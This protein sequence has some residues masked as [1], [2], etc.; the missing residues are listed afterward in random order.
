MTLYIGIAARL[1]HRGALLSRAAQF[2]RWAEIGLFQQNRPIPDP[3]TTRNWRHCRVARRLGPM[4]SAVRR[5][6]QIQR[7]LQPI[8]QAEVALWDG[9]SAAD[10]YQCRPAFPC[11]R[12]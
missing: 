7:A 8:W 9:R 10:L 12:L 6:L 11:N 5:S 4:K 1:Q 2:P 3:R